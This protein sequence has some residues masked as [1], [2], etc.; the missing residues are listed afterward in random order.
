M[1]RFGN[2]HEKSCTRCNSKD[3]ERVRKS[4]LVRMITMGASN[5]KRYQCTK[6]WKSFYIVTKKAADE[7]RYQYQ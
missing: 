3:F 4:A 7:H 2:I 6:C 5:L 1:I